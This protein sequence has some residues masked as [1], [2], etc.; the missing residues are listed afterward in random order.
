MVMHPFILCFVF[1]PLDR[2]YECSVL[3]RCD[4]LMCQNRVVQHGIQVRLQ[5]FNTEKKGWGVRCLD[6]ID[7]GTFVCTYSGSKRGPLKTCSIILPLTWCVPW[8]FFEIRV[9]REVCQ[10]NLNLQYDWMDRRTLKSSVMRWW[11]TNKSIWSKTNLRL[12]IFFPHKSVH[13]MPGLIFLQ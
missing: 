12:L 5:V 10:C 3:C 4:K 2:I 13:P 9:G 7:R 6:D 8:M 1:L 11:Q